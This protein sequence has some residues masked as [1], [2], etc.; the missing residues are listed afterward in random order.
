ME[1]RALKI[2]YAQ[3]L[4]TEQAT[5][6]LGDGNQEEDDVNAEEDDDFQEVDEEEDEFE[7]P[8]EVYPQTEPIIINGGMASTQR[9]LLDGIGSIVYEG[10]YKHQM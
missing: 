3:Q 8:Q 4:K 9:L 10:A 7:E 2:F 1:N 6:Y 5:E